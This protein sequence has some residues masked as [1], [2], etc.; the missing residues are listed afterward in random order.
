[1]QSFHNQLKNHM[2]KTIFIAL[3]SLSMSASAFLD[4]N[5][6]SSPY[7]DNDWPIWTPMYWME[8]ISD[9]NTS[10]QRYQGYPY[11]YNNR[12]Y[13]IYATRFDMSQMPTPDQAYQAESLPLPA[14]VYS[15]PAAQSF[16]NPD[17]LPSPYPQNFSLPPL[18]NPYTDR[19]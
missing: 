1:M 3:I 18:P 7:D 9:N 16:A 8:K 12:P 15:T 5:H 2:K 4:F 10:N 11:P 6:Y 17:F 13:N 14:P 19:F